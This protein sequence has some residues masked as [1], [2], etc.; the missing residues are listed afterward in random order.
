MK[1]SNF[2]LTIIVIM[3]F[4]LYFFP[5]IEHAASS[6]GTFDQ[7]ST[8]SVNTLPYTSGWQYPLAGRGGYGMGMGYMHYPTSVRPVMQ[9]GAY[10]YNPSWSR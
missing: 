2:L 6:P 10:F 7:L 9:R 3:I 1:N 5:L 8:S 4:I